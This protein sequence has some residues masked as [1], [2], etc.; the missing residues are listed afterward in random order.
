[1]QSKAGMLAIVFLMSV[2]SAASAQNF[3]VKEEVKGGSFKKLQGAAAGLPKSALPGARFMS[4]KAFF[5]KYKERNKAPSGLYILDA[6]FIPPALP[7]ALKRDGLTLHKDGPLLSRDKT[8]QTM[9]V[10]SPV[11]LAVEPDKRRKSGGGFLNDLMGLVV[12]EAK[13]ASPFP[14]RNVTAMATW[15]TP[16]GFCRTVEAKTQADAWGFAAGI[17]A[18][19]YRPHTRI[20]GM[21]TRAFIGPREDTDTCANCDRESSRKTWRVGCVWPAYSANGLHYAAFRDGAFQ[22]AWYY[23]W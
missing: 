8:K 3:S 23:Q 1:M 4:A 17:P 2:A 5:A 18:W 13:A 19:I 6:D 22:F 15:R 16:S 9:L 10:L 12:P 11:S 20:E 14:L 21:E 7:E